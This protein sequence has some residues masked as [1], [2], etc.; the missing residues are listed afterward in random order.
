MAAPAKKP[1][2]KGGAKGGAPA[3][4]KSYSNRSL[5]EVSGD[6]V[7]RTKQTCP[8][9]GTGVFLAKHANRSTCGKCG[10]TEFSK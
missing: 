10:Y 4:K 7:K 2:A 1:A 9:C 3:K 8:K 5:Y 6:T